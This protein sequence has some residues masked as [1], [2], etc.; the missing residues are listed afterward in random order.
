MKVKLDFITNSSS[1]CI[2]MLTNE[3]VDKK[4]MI[5]KVLNSIKDKLLESIAKEVA[6]DTRQERKEN[7]T[8]RYYITDKE[9]VDQ[10][11]RSKLIYT[12]DVSND[13]ENS[14]L[15]SIFHSLPP[16]DSSTREVIFSYPDSKIIVI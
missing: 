3:K 5:L 9:V 8:D 15:R 2:I 16:Y 12:L 6:N 7:I 4:D 11:K 10:I 13:T 14:L 1:A